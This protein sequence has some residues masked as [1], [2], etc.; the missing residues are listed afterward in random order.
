MRIAVDFDGTLFEEEEAI[1]NAAR[2][3]VGRDLT[4]E[5]FRRLDKETRAK[6]YRKSIEDY[7]DL[8]RPIRPM[9]ELVNSLKAAGHSI[10]IVTGRPRSS[11]DKVRYI[12]DK[13]GVKY[14]EIM[15][16]ED[17]G[18]KDEVWKT[19]KFVEHDIDII[20]EDKL[21]NLNFIRDNVKDRRTIIIGMLL[22]I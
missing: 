18:V 17:L 4:M 20:I 13:H 3:V 1:R 12:L 16:R 2:D 5:E 6:I 8:F 10:I 14:D 21:E 22:S 9:I 15:C 19:R 7:A 11:E